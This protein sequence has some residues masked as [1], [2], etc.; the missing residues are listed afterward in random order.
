[1]K[2]IS[3]G[4]IDKKILFA[5]I[6]GCFKM[7]ANI[8]LYHSDASIV[9]HPCILGINTSLGIFLSVFPF[10]YINRTKLICKKKEKEDILIYNFPG[11]NNNNNKFILIILV[12]ILDFIQKF[13]S[14]FFVKLFLENFWIF[15][16]FFLL[17]FSRI[18][19]NEKQYL[20]HFISLVAIIIIGIIL[21]VI[22]YH[23]EE[24]PFLKVFVTLL[25]EIIYSLE[26]VISKFI[27]NTKYYTPYIICA[28][29]GTLEL[30]LFII[31]LIIFT[32]IPISCIDYMN[33]FN[34]TYVDDISDYFENI[35]FKE[36]LIFILVMFSRLIFLLFG[37]LLIDAFTPIHLILILIIGEISFLFVDAYDWKLYLKLVFFIILIFFILIFTEIIELNV[38]NI[39]KN[40]KKNIFQRSNSERNNI[41]QMIMLINLFILFNNIIILL[42]FI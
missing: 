6:G 32:Q 4:T 14:L 24:I 18:I 26:N 30:I 35:T 17:I 22:N 2:I 20:H 42:L 3:L 39:Q 28:T 9:S 27:M 29:A 7:I 10:L 8:V 25:I 41:D 5:I 11:T 34:D 38:W 19:L 21:I 37:F 13:I 23:G 36:I 1:M 15:D 31:I 40:T 33:C 16:S 12:S